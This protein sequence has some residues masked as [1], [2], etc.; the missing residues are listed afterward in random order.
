MTDVIDWI[1]AE[2]PNDDLVAMAVLERARKVWGGETVYV[3]L[4]PNPVTVDATSKVKTQQLS[5][6]TVQ[7]R[8]RNDH[9]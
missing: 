7:R 3:R 8:K 2:L 1:R 5:R 9:C 4:P 6:R